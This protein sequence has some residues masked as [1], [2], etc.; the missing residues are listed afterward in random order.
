LR[1]KQSV[2]PVRK[3]TGETPLYIN[4]TLS[5]SV[6]V[7]LTP[8]A[9]PNDVLARK[10][11]GAGAKVLLMA[12][13]AEAMGSGY[14]LI[15]DSALAGRCGISRTSVI[16]NKA[17]L[18]IAGLIDKYGLPRLQVQAYRFLHPDMI[19]TNTA[20]RF[21]VT[22]KSR[23]G[24]GACSVCGG[25]NNVS[26]GRCIKCRKQSRAD[27]SVFAFMR[28]HPEADFVVMFT[29]LGAYENHSKQAIRN[30]YYKW[31]KANGAACLSGLPNIAR[32]S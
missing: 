16:E 13:G 27:E 10:D 3:R 7:V 9:I 6:Q 29:V 15:S 21:V 22:R 4:N 30:A 8:G 19:G 14:F 5:E 2:E 28:E 11:L 1:E 25:S 12:M 18:E 24:S 17:N 32:P 23:N 31:Q 20:P 26:N